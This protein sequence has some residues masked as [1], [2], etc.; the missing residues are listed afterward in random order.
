MVNT[1]ILEILFRITMWTLSSKYA[2]TLEFLPY[3]ESPMQYMG[4]LL[5]VGFFIPHSL[6]GILNYHPLPQAGKHI[7]I[8][9][10]SEEIR[11]AAYCIMRIISSAM[12]MTRVK[13]TLGS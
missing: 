9:L 13:L 1:A 8:A 12:S 6:L 10:E 2:A 4:H 11:V 3:W 5:I 7:I